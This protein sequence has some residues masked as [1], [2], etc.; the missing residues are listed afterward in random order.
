MRNIYW[1]KLPG[2]QLPGEVG[3][4]EKHIS[5]FLYFLF[6]RWMIKTHQVEPTNTRVRDQEIMQTPSVFISCFQTPQ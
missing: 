1:L 5:V 6:F 2:L 3:N 4:N